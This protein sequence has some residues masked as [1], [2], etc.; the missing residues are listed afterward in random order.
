MCVQRRG[1][2]TA[3]EHVIRLAVI[4]GRR[5]CHQA[6]ETVQHGVLVAVLATLLLLLLVRIVVEHEIVLELRI[7]QVSTVHQ[8][9]S[10]EPIGA[11]ARVQH[12]VGRREAATGRDQLVS[13]R[14]I[15]EGV[16]VHRRGSVVAMKAASSTV[17]NATIANAQ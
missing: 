4:I 8:G 11:H 10:R 12:Q 14:S 13:G 1:T 15:L 6:A 2:T 9:Q 7:A 5:R 17:T 3:K 16:Q